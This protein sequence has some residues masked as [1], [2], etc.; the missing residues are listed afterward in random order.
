MQ[1]LIAATG[2]AARVM[3][4]GRLGTLQPGKAADF[5][6]LGANPL[7]DIRNT[8]RIEAVWLAGQPV[9]R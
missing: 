3:Q 2:G 6:V 1:A 4:L 5:I 9:E 8:R 7:D